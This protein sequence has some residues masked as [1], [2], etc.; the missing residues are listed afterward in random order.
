M[1][2]RARVFLI[3]TS[4]LGREFSERAPRALCK[5]GVR[6]G[7]VPANATGGAL[8]F[9]DFPEARFNFFERDVRWCDGAYVFFAW[10]CSRQNTVTSMCCL[11]LGFA[12]GLKSTSSAARRGALTRRGVKIPVFTSFSEL[13]ALEANV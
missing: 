12:H 2:P 8:A 11:S 7:H 1:L 10:L 3:C 5:Q 9:Q 13:R 6:S 4:W